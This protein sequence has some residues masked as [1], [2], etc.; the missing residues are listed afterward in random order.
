MRLSLL[1]LCACLLFSQALIAGDMEDTMNPHY[2]QNFSGFEGV[3]F[4]CSYDESDAVLAKICERASV[5]VRLLAASTNIK[6]ELIKPNKFLLRGLVKSKKNY[7]G[8]TYRLVASRVDATASV[9]A[10]YGE[11]SYNDYYLNAVELNAKDSTPRSGDLELW[12]TYVIGGGSG[13]DAVK[14]YSD[15]I[16]V[17]LKKAVTVFLKYAN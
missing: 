6:L 3:V 15:T 11:L 14:P 13:L 17:G 9:K 16:E 10:I 8:L 1:P 4:M 2:K 12:S 5:D 7:I